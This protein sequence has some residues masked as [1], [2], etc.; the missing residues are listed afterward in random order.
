MARKLT[1][2]DLAYDHISQEWSA[3][4]DDFDTRRRA[5][6]LIQQFL[7]P[8]IAGKKVL[9][10]GCGLGTFSHALSDF[11]P[12][13]HVA[14][15]IAPTLVERLRGELTTVDAK[16][17]DLMDLSATL[18]TELFDAVLCSEV[19]EHTPNPLR[20]IEN[21]S[22]HVAPGGYLAISCPNQLWK[23]SLHIAQTLNIRK[24]YLGY[25]NWLWGHQVRD[26]IL[27]SGLE[28]VAA[29]GIH[30]VPWQVVPKPFLRK[31]DRF[32]EKRSFGLAVNL[33]ILA[34]RPAK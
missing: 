20:A 12:I 14:I 15:D 25:E 7:R 3:F 11:D 33:A 1:D 6:V 13:R 2:R 29:T 19:I 22:K 5:E 32:M 21:L 23:W 27:R 4:I 31:M 16:V 18:G 34:R 24:K 28:V 26:Q 9:D 10:A 30:L 8:H 17:A